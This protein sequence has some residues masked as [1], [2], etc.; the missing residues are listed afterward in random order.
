LSAILTDGEAPKPG[1]ITNWGYL[2]L[3][4]QLLYPTE[5]YCKTYFEEE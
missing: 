4:E 2:R 5:R 1:I 3:G